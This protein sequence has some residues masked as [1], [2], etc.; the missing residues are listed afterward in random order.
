M[1]DYLAEDLL[2]RERYRGH[3]G[4]GRVGVSYNEGQRIAMALEITLRNIAKLPREAAG[5]TSS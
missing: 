2:W 3:P 1:N 4:L 5:W